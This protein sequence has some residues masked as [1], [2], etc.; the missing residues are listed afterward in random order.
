LRT[1]RNNQRS[2]AMKIA[3]LLKGF[4]IISRVI[5]AIIVAWVLICLFLLALRCDIPTI[6]DKRI[7][8]LI[9]QVAALETSQAVQ[10]SSRRAEID[11]L[12]G[13]IETLKDSM[14]ARIGG[15]EE[16]LHNGFKDLR[17]EFAQVYGDEIAML[18]DSIRD[19][20]GEQTALKVLMNMTDSTLNALRA[21]VE[22][23]TNRL[24]IKILKLDESRKAI[25]SWEP[26]VDLDDDG[27]PTTGVTYDV[28]LAWG[29]MPKFHAADS[30]TIQTGWLYAP[31]A[32][33]LYFPYKQDS[34]YVVRVQSIDAKG[35]KLAPAVW[36][37]LVY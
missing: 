30:V 27:N 33:T 35:N 17:L 5:T 34:C 15:S 6:E 28:S 20:K 4:K 31:N 36:D 32:D 16:R 19:I 24:G 12:S 21:K 26:V 23:D 25:L 3:E 8:V 37:G 14:F 10:D 1:T 22:S 11:S 29:E 13:V 7:P 9:E 2:E 18:E